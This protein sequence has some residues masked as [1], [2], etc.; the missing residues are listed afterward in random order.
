MFC[1]TGEVGNV[2][3]ASAPAHYFTTDCSMA[4]VLLWFAVGCFWCQ[5]SIDVSSNVC[6]YYL[7]SVL[8]AEWPYFG[9]ELLPR[10]TI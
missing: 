6:L 2:N 9:K 1:T 5:S 10:L 4:V 8:V 7:S 3:L